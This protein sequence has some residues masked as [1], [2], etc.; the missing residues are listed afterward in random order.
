MNIQQVEFITSG[1]KLGQFPDEDL[2]EIALAGRSNVGKSS[3]INCLLRRKKMARISSRP[4]KTQTINFFRINQAFIFADVPGYGFAKVSKELRASWKRMMESYF[5]QRKQLRAVVQ[6]VD[7]RHAPTADDV[8]TY[9]FL[10]QQGL[11]VILVA[12]K[13]DKIVKGKWLAHLQQIRKTLHIDQSVPVIPFSAV[14]L[15]GKEELWSQ[16]KSI[17]INETMPE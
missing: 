1:V 6:L 16:L 15:V 10:V 8:A 5:C 9:H 7:I 11:P 13:A 17:V 2:P 12:T 14:T 4:G 3:L